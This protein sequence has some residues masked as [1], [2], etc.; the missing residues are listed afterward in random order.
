VLDAARGIDSAS[1]ADSEAHRPLLERDHDEAR[2]RP[3]EERMVVG[4]RL[5]PAQAE[6]LGVQTRRLPEVG[7]VED[8][9]LR[10][11]RAAFLG[12]ILAD[13]EQ[14][15]LADRVQVR[16]IARASR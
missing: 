11:G 4:F 1:A 6:M 16:R 10:P 9:E 2:A 13:A 7:D 14:Q 3:E 15:V 12:R 8:R 5:R